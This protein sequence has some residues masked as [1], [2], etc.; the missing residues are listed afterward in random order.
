MLVSITALIDVNR[1]QFKHPCIWMYS[2]YS[3]SWSNIFI[4]FRNAK[5]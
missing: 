3:L 1:R 5:L 2:T 4:C